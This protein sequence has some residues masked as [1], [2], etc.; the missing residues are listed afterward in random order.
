VQSTGRFLCDSIKV[1][2]FLSQEV[3]T[4]IRLS[5]LSSSS[6]SS[7][8]ANLHVIECRLLELH[9]NKLDSIL[10]LGLLAQELGKQSRAWTHSSWLFELSL[11][12]MR[13]LSIGA[14]SVLSTVSDCFLR[15]PSV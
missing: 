9:G 14:N 2:M 13:V 7:L 5:E 12:A 10:S 6:S 3:L 4:C 8:K 15:L 11:G 1:H